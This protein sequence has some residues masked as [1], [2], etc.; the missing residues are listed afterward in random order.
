MGSGV[1]YA[2]AMFSVLATALVYVS[3]TSSGITVTTLPYSGLS[4]PRH[5]TDCGVNFTRPDLFNILQPQLAGL[6]ISASELSQSSNVAQT[7]CAGV[8]DGHEDMISYEQQTTLTTGDT[9]QSLYA[10]IA[11]G[12]PTALAARDCGAVWTV[13]WRA[14]LLLRLVTQ[15]LGLEPIFLWQE[16]DMYTLESLIL[17]AVYCSRWDA[18]S[19]FL[20]DIWIS[21]LAPE[22]SFHRPGITKELATVGRA[23][24]CELAFADAMRH[25]NCWKNNLLSISTSV[26]NSNEHLARFWYTYRAASEPCS[27]HFLN[28]AEETCRTMLIEFHI[29]KEQAKNRCSPVGPVLYE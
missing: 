21:L 24:A 17:S 14:A 27:D 15:E 10:L 5:A 6:G 29:S 9:L 7:V 18:V 19:H 23:D 4:R 2:I 11:H 22:V 20:A 3:R 13:M 8:L 12:L 1:A 28:M 25:R 16:A 26:R